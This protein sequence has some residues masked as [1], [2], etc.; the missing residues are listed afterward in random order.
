MPT[1]EVDERPGQKSSAAAGS[2]SQQ[3][4]A[5]P[6][7]STLDAVLS[8]EAVNPED[9]VQRLKTSAA[10]V[11]RQKKELARALRNAER[12]RQRI[13]QKAKQLT[14]A[15]LLSV[16]RMRRDGAAK[17]LAAA[18]SKASSSTSTPSVQ[19][20]LGDDPMVPPDPTSE[21]ET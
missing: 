14:D 1:V 7:T 12:R 21:M 9:L 20:A 3:D 15:D 10:E 11:K 8:A 6:C 5:P 19:E 4:T 13:K 2:G 17:K 16:M 18:S